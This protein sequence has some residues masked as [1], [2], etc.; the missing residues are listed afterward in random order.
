MD[1]F[2][3]QDGTTISAILWPIIY[4]QETADEVRDVTYIFVS[5]ILQNS[6]FRKGNHVSP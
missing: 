1:K 4:K 2:K 5:S 3:P 6:I